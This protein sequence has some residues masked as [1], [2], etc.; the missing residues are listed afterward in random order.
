MREDYGMK[1]RQ[2][3]TGVQREVWDRGCVSSRDPK[4]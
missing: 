3:L 1:D 2:L 4:K